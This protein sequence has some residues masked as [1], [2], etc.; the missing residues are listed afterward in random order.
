MTHQLPVRHRFVM[1]G[2]C[3]NEHHCQHLTHGFTFSRGHFGSAAR[4]Q[5]SE[6][7]TVPS[8]HHQASIRCCGERQLIHNSDLFELMRS[9][10]IQPGLQ[11][12]S[13]FTEGTL[14]WSY[15]L[16]CTTSCFSPTSCCTYCQIMLQSTLT[17]ARESCNRTTNQ[18]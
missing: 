1:L 16:T 6:K 8:L 10:I 7:T 15:M 9:S 3:L 12:E 2:G 5:A 13:S 4:V 17:A 18:S 14:P 11:E